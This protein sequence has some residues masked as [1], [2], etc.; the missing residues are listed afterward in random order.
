MP[1]ILL[2]GQKMCE[3]NLGFSGSNAYA[4]GTWAGTF[5]AG[6]GVQ[7]FG[8]NITIKNPDGAS[9]YGSTTYSMYGSANFF[10]GVTNAY[11][12]DGGGINTGWGSFFVPV[13]VAHVRCSFEWWTAVLAPGAHSI[14][15]GLYVNASAQVVFD[16]SD[17]G[18]S[19]C[20]E[21]E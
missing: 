10:S 12:V 9:V 5:G 1:S 17:G 8:H 2:D 4:G 13:N 19:V 20:W 15:T 11:W 18:A 3:R 16:T 6:S 7:L 14:L 21:H